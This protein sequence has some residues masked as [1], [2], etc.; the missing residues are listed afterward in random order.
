MVTKALPLDK[1]VVTEFKI[2]V[3]DI[4]LRTKKLANSIAVRVPRTGNFIEG[5]YNVSDVS[6]LLMNNIKAVV[7]IFSYEPILISLTNANGMLNDIPCSGL[8]LMYGS[9]DS[10]EVKSPEAGKLVRVTYL[11]S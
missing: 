8:F 6:T 10:V 9:F 2:T 1:S 3:A 11:Y 5:D 7:A 4:H